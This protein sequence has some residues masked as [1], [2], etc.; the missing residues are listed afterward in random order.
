MTTMVTSV[1]SLIDGF[2]FQPIKIR[3]LPTYDTLRKLKQD[4]QRNSTSVSCALGGGRHGYLGLILDANAY[5]IKVSI[6]A[7]GAAQP[8]ITPVF[9]GDQPI[10]TGATA[11]AKTEEL[12]IFNHQTYAWRMYKNVRSALRKQLVE[13]VKDT[14]ISPLM[15]QV[16]GYNNV[17]AREL[18]RH[19]FAEYGEVGP[20]DVYKNNTRFDDAAC[21]NKLAH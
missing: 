21:F 3:G 17:T 9:P 11:E 19:L 5:A 7:A 4:L 15:D 18:L 6:T 12:R 2:P 16:T 10:F 20:T 8:F 1:D 14:Y 13:S